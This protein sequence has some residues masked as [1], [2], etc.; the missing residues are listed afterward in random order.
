[1][2]V[3]ASERTNTTAS[4]SNNVFL[5]PVRTFPPDIDNVTIRG[6]APYVKNL[7]K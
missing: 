6:H 5:A 3:E 4:P 7:A 1:M 2:A